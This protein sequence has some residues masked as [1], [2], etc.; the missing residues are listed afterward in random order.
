MG[1]QSELVI[2]EK[3]DR[4][5]CI[6]LNDAKTN[7]AL[8]TGLIT[9]LRDAWID[10]ESDPEMRVAILTG[11]GKA[12]CTGMDLE[13]A[14]SGVIADFDSCMPNIG[15]EVSKPI[16]GAI[17]GWAIGAGMGLAVCSDIRVMSERAKFLFPEAK[18]G[19]AGG[20]LDFVRDMPYAIA[21]EIW[22]T[23]EPLDAKRAYE[24]G[25]VNRVVPPEQL[26][27]EATRFATIIQENAP[28]TMKMLKMS[29]VMH[30]INVKNAWLML[31]SN[32]IRPQAESEDL[33]EGICAF[34]EKRKPE[35]KGR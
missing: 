5:A 16:I 2:Y 14:E 11:S 34:K 17:N 6:T 25:L 27:E 33:K 15:V 28:L 13:E 9:R 31:R 4:M 7:N 22:L 21:M 24:I 32:Y 30:T 35:F 10:F 1:T 3:R 19:Y 20:G 12:F 23:G 26:M 29:A 8:T 18:F